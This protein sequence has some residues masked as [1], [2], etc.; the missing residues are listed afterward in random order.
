MKKTERI[1]DML[2]YL[3][4][5][6]YFNL[7]DL[8]VRYDISKSTALRDIQSLE[9]IG[10][11]IYSELGRNGSYKII[12]NSVLSPIYFSVDE[13]YAL[14][15]SILTLNGYKTKPFNIESIALENKFKHVLPDNVSKNISI[16]ERTLSFEVTNHSNFSPYL[17]EILQGIFAERV[18][19]LTYLKKDA[20]KVLVAQFIRIESKF[21][22][23]YAKIFNFEANHVQIIRCDKILS[24]EET[25]NTNPKNL[26]E[27]LSYL[28]N[29]HRKPDATDFIVIVNQ[30][31]KD[32]FDKENYPSMKIKKENENYSITGYF[33]KQEVEFIASYFLNFGETIIS[34]QP[35]MLKELIYNK[36]LSIKQ[37]LTSL[38]ES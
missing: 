34:I 8:M 27:L 24:I 1:N 38:R 3:N 13:M 23:W 9:E 26:E 17:K 21:G 14:Y 4:N 22:Q 5:K 12:A 30:K 31:G 33:N 15:F 37:H 19:Q 18:Y 10:V 7:R 6:R 35:V 25:S 11:P 36:V 20:E 29:F 16:M 2:I 28:I 32:I